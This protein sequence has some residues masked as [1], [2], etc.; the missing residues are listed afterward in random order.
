MVGI[1]LEILTPAK[2]AYSSNVKA[3]TVPGTIGSFQ[4]LVNHAPLISTFEIGI[5]KVEVDDQKVEYFSTSGGTIEVLNNKIRILADSIETVNE[6]DIQRAKNALA[7]AQERLA[8]KSIEKIDVT[9]AESALA[10]ANNR[11]N[12]YEKYF[13]FVAK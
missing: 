8:K 9:R 1:N 3:V 7:R 12:F 5:I 6:L 4:V 10:R 11:I 13:N 2:L